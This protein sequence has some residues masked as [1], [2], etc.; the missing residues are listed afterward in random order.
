MK[1]FKLVLLICII[2]SCRPSMKKEVQAKLEE[3]Y[4]EK[5]KVYNSAYSY[6]LTT[7]QFQA[8]PKRNKNL[9][10][11]GG[12]NEKMEYYSDNYIGKHLGEQ[13][14]LHF[15]KNVSEYTSP[16]FVF[17]ELGYEDIADSAKIQVDTLNIEKILKDKPNVY[18]T[19]YCYIFK[20]LTV[21]TKEELLTGIY[22]VIEPYKTHPKANIVIYLSFFKSEFLDSHTLN[23]FKFNRKKHSAPDIQTNDRIYV[24]QRL[25]LYFYTDKPFQD[26]NIDTLYKYTQR[27]TPEKFRV[28][29][30][31]LNWLYEQSINGK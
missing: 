31:N 23:H 16:V 11:V 10:F 21:D 22:K 1:I 4:G 3:K 14:S 28:P 2:S 7:Y 18:L 6:V 15:K 20:E 26:F 27:V 29:P 9:V 5:F 17:C 25:D 19:I 8:A 24:T 12:H 30:T 13:A